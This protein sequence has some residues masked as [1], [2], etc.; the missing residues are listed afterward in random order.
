M[1]APRS[2][3]SVSSPSADDSRGGT[4]DERENRGACRRKSKREKEKREKETREKKKKKKKEKIRGK[5]VKRPIKSDYKHQSASI[6]AIL[7]G[8]P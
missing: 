4:V 1:P 8:D 6:P 2:T 5:E 7:R 3:A